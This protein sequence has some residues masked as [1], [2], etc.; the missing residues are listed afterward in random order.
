MI[1]RA[2]YNSQRQYEIYQFVSDISEDDI[3]DIFENDPQIIVNFIRKHG[4][5]IYSDYIKQEE[6]A[7][8]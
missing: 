1:I 3:K 4:K 8:V 5:K 2:R 7:I 6:R